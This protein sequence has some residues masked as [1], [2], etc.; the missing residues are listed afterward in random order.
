MAAVK[1][2]S[3]FHFSQT[4]KLEKETGREGW[5][6]RDGRRGEMDEKS[7]EGNRKRDKDGWKRGREE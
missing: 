5:S 3:D 2:F 6:E 7:G 1:I 4:L